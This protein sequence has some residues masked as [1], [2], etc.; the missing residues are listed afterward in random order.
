MT[1]LGKTI[2]AV[3]MAGLLAVVWFAM[4][5]DGEARPQQ[6]VQT[7]QLTP[8]QRAELATPPAPKKA[9]PP[10]VQ[11]QPPPPDDDAPEDGNGS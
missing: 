2:F 11:H 6:P 3:G 4:R 5:S 9:E 1:N 7:A 10:V 8:A